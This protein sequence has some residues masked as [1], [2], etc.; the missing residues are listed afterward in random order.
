MRKIYIN[1]VLD[2]GTVS[3]FG[4]NTEIIDFVAAVP[5][6]QIGRNAGGDLAN[7]ALAELWLD[8][9]YSNTPTAFVRRAATGVC[10]PIS[11]GATGNLPTGSAPAL[12]LSLNGSGASVGAANGWAVDSSGNNNGFTVVG[13]WTT[14]TPP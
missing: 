13:T 4:P 11:L 7:G 6:W 9:V 3:T 14:D 1:G 8:D 5:T 12:Y 10:K 2:A